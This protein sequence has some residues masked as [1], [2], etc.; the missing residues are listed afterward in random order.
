[1]VEE[2][3]LYFAVAKKKG[4]VRFA[5]MYAGL[6]PRSISAEES[7]SALGREHEAPKD[8]VSDQEALSSLLGTGV[9]G[10]DGKEYLKAHKWSES[11]LKEK[12]ARFKATARAHPAF[13]RVSPG[14]INIFVELG[15]LGRQQSGASHFKKLVVTKKFLFFVFQ[16]RI[17][18]ISFQYRSDGPT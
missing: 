2:G 1:V 3:L 4:N 5:E 9:F 14:G 12:I 6:S 11:K 16:D 7:L 17:G 10:P 8:S 13:L 15:F 18:S